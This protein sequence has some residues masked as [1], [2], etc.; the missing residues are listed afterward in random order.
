MPGRKWTGEEKAQHCTG[1]ADNKYF[2]STYTDNGYAV[3]S[4][5]SM[6]APYVSGA[7]ALYKAQHPN[8]MPVEVME[9]L[10]NSGSTPSTICDEGA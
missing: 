1:N 5:T 6:A 3:E 10:L 2:D 9:A 4:G 8:A 7:A